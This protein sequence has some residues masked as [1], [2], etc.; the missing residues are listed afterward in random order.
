MIRPVLFVGGLDSSGGAGLLRDAATAAVLDQP[1]RVAATAVTAQGTGGV[2]AVHPVPPGTVAA[3]IGL[4]A[5]EGLATVKI[6]MLATAATVAAVASALPPGVPMVLDP[7]L[8]AS[9]GGVLLKPD[10]L[11]ALLALLVP[12]AALL[13]PNIPELAAIGGALGLPSGAAEDLVVQGLLDAGC[14]AVLVKGGHRDTPAICEDRLYRGGHDPVAM[15]APRLAR[16]LRG[17]GCHLASAI[18]VHLGR[19][20]GMAEAVALARDHLRARFEAG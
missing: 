15:R 10:G 12:R 11:A 18:A 9:S 13:T 14:G 7:V 4:A 2:A 19:G 8:R 6:G 5:Q 1:A 16:T 20:A 17:T 3:Q